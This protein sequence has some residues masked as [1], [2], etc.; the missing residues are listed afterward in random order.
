MCVLLFSQLL[1]ETFFILKRNE[2]DITIHLHKTSCKVS[3]ILSDIN[4][5][6]LLE[7]FLKILKYQIHEN[8]S[9]CSLTVPCRQKG[10]QTD[11]MQLRCGQGSQTQRIILS[12]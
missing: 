9:S 7:R 4:E 3:V 5:T 11:M 6:H 8:L 2:Q 10:G 12:L 1:S